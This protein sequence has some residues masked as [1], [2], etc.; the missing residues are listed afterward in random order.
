MVGSLMYLPCE[1]ASPLRM[2][3]STSIAVDLSGSM[4]GRY[5]LFAMMPVWLG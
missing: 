1:T 4:S 5:S 3:A 2:A